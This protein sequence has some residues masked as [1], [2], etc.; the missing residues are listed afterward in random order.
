MQTVHSDSQA[1]ADILNL[2][3]SSVFTD[4]DES[5]APSL[6]VSPYSKLLHIT[7]SVAGVRT[8]LEAT[9]PHRTRRDPS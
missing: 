5:N 1:K 8:L 3:F 4:G 7:V 2:Q 9:K 6:G